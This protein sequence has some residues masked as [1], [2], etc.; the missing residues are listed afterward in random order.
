MIIL[1]VI[2][3]VFFS[4]RALRDSQVAQ[5]IKAYEE[6]FAANI[7]IDGINIS[8]MT[9]QEAYE[10]VFNNNR[11]VSAP[12]MRIWSTMDIIM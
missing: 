10:A 7:Y 11:R 5:E 9:P 4:A 6:I 12:G 8:G 1:A 2:L 3:A